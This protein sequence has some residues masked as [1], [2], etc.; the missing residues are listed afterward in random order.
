MVDVSLSPDE[1]VLRLHLQSGRFRSGEASGRWRLVS[2]KW[3]HLV[4]GVRAADGV[5]YAFRFECS[6]YPRSPVT[7]QP[8]DLDPDVPLT[9][10]RWPTGRSRVPL[11][12]NPGW[13][14]G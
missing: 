11:A 5:E 10:S 2:L 3:P 8:W 6:N 14:D 1:Q 4:I 12:F 7:A 13:K 9:V